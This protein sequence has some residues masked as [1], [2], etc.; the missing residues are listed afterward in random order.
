MAFATLDRVDWCNHRRLLGPIGFVPPAEAD[1]ASYAELENPAV[2][3]S[4]LEPTSLRQT[5]RGSTRQHCTALGGMLILMVLGV[6]INQPQPWTID[7]QHL[8]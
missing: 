1:A 8:S 5:R 2:A 4:G 7:A 6:W 3:A